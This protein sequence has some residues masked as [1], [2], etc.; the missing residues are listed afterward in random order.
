MLQSL[1]FDKQSGTFMD[2]ALPDFA[3]TGTQ[4]IA[5]TYPLF[6]GIAT[7]EQ[8]ERVA[9]TVHRGFLK[10]GGWVTSNHNTGQQWDSPNGWAPMQWITYRGLER[11]GFHDEARAGAQSWIDDNVAIY[12]QHGRLL[13]KYNVEMIAAKREAIDMAEDRDLFRQAM[14]DIGI[15]VAR[16]D[17]AHTLEEALEKQKDIGFPTIIRPSFPLGGTGGGIFDEGSN[18]DGENLVCFNLPNDIAGT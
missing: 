17:I 15:E 5:M 10:A 12:Q 3:V 7:Q 14:T 2:L 4:S 8:A 6:F 1:F 13:E 16:A 9:K 11:Y 18:T